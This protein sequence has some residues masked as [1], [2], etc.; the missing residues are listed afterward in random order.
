MNSTN[1]TLLRNTGKNAPIGEKNIQMRKMESMSLKVTGGV[2]TTSSKKMTVDS[3]EKKI[4][5]LHFLKEFTSCEPNSNSYSAVGKVEDFSSSNI[6]LAKETRSQAG[7]ISD[8]SSATEL[9]PN[10]EID[11]SLNSMLMAWYQSGYATG[12]Y[13]AEQHYLNAQKNL[14]KS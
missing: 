6:D 14:S 8:G 13:V 1:P 2:S 5:D 12:Y 9:H 4:N 3:V 10:L 7:N 11:N